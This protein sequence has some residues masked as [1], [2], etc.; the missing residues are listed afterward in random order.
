MTPLPIDPRGRITPEFAV[1][2][3]TL[4]RPAADTPDA[5]DRR[6]LDA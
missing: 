3:R 1:P 2:S 5:A 6:D 4:L